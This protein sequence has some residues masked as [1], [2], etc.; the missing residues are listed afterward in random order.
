MLRVF[1]LAACAKCR[2][3]AACF[4]RLHAEVPAVIARNRPSQVNMFKADGSIMHF[5]HP[6]GELRSSALCTDGRCRLPAACSTR[7]RTSQAAPCVNS[8]LCSAVQA[9]FQA[10]TYVVSGTPEEK[11]T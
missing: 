4:A 3:S 2:R 8:A 9:A 10:N 5:Q 11:C 1:V 7:R 6:K